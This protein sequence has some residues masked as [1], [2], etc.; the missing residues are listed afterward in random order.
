MVGF[1]IEFHFRMRSSVEHGKLETSAGGA[2]DFNS[3]GLHLKQGYNNPM[4]GNSKRPAPSYPSPCFYPGMKTNHKKKG[5]WRLCCSWKFELSASAEGEKKPQPVDSPGASIWFSTGLQH[6]SLFPPLD[7]GNTPS[8]FPPHI[9][10][11]SQSL[12]ILLSESS[13]KMIPLFWAPPSLFSV[14]LVKT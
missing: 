6:I 2:V 1:G 8:P 3:R 11:Q 12:H 9:W 14:Y 7:T 13:S 10:L 5:K 4:L